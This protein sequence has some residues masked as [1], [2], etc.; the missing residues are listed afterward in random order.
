M[1]LFWTEPKDR[2]HKN[3]SEIM[4]VESGG[5]CIKLDDDEVRRSLDVKK[6]VKA[7]S[8]MLNLNLRTVLIFVLTMS[9]CSYPTPLGAKII[10][11]AYASDELADKCS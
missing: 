4:M 5:I 2:T 7:R 1:T 8:E 3:E 6:W 11:S 9:K 10:L